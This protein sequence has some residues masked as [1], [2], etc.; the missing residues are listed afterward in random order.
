MRYKA[1]TQKCAHTN[2]PA[3]NSIRARAR[4]SHALLLI[5]QYL[6]YRPGYV[7]YG[8]SLEWLVSALVYVI[9]V[10]ILLLKYRQE[11]RLLFN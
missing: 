3:L 9:A 1:R 5:R 7:V 11:Q 4:Q 8:I 6:K 2:S 10:A